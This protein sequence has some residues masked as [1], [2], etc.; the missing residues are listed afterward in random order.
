MKVDFVTDASG[1]FRIYDNTVY[2]TVDYKIN[3][4]ILNKFQSNSNLSLKVIS[5]DHTKTLKSA[6]VA[7]CK[8]YHNIYNYTALFNDKEFKEISP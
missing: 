7:R 2:D 1:Y 5:S 3:Q 6:N 8:K 4:F